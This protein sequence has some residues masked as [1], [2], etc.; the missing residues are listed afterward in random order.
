MLVV[1]VPHLA[2]AYPG[3]TPDFQTDVIPY[4]ASCHSSIDESSL[5]GAGEKAYGD[6]SE[7]D[8]QTLVSHI[9]A[10]DANSTITLE[11]PPQ[12]EAGKNFQ[13]T[14]RVTGGSGPVVGVGLVDRSHRW[15]ARSAIT[16]GWQMVGAPT[17]IGPE[18]SP[19]T[20]WLAKRPERLGRDLAYVNI[21]GVE[22]DAV[23][24]KWSKSKVIFNMTA[25]AKAGDYPMV[26]VYYYGTEKATPLGHESHPIYGKL[27]RGTYTG[28]S[29]RVK[30]STTHVISVR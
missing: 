10:V 26:G 11:F 1:I 12:V 6:L 21:T 5:Q 23:A 20:E 3:G 4:C 22:S 15:F 25:P 30:F 24:E 29:G 19:Q 28:K 8:R 13:V 2:S 7:E 14:V 18:G 16:T 27:T 17:I 9:K